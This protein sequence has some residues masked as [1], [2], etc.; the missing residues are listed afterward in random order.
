MPTNPNARERP[1]NISKRKLKIK[2]ERDK[3]EAGVSFLA[4]SGRHM[5]T[6]LRAYAHYRLWG[7]VVKCCYL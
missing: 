3:P 5:C 7:W 6:Q 2:K 4:M 1:R